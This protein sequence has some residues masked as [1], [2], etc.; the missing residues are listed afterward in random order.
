MYVWGTSSVGVLGECVPEL[1]EIG[2]L[3]LSRSPFDIMAR[4]GRR[5][6]PTQERYF[7]AG[8]SRLRWPDSAHNATPPELSRAVHFI[9]LPL[10]WNDM[11]PFYQLSGIVLGVAKEL[12]YEIRW[13]GYW[14]SP[15]DPAHY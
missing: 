10:D 9:P 1:R 7:Q 14:R 13:G 6:E 2:N 4:E 5:D 11:M 12:G 15:H 8:L 3:T